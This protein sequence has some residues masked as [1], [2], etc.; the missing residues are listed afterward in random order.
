[1]PASGSV[2]RIVAADANILINFIHVQRLDLLGHL[3]EYEFVMPE[4]VR[5][6]ITDPPP[7]RNFVG[8]L[9]GNI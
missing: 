5:G 6:E 2:V 9:I 1:M 8:Q 4:E 7:A 3:P